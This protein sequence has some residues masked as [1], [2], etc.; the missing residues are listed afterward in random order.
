[1]QEVMVSVCCTTYNHEKYVRDALE[2][3]VDQET[4]FLY[5]VIVHDDASTD[6]TVEII[7]EYAEKYPDIIKPIYQEENQYSKQVNIYAQYIYPNTKGKYIA[8]CEGDD[9]WID[10]HKLQIQVDFMEKHTGFS[11]C[12][13]NTCFLDTRSGEERI[14]YGTEEKE[15]GILDTIY[16]GGQSFHTSSLLFYREYALEQPEFYHFTTKMKDYPM[17]IYLSYSGKIKYFPQVMSVYRVLTEGSWSMAYLDLGRQIE[18]LQELI[19]MLEGF[20]LYSDKQYHKEVQKSMRDKR[21]LLA[22]LQGDFETIHS[23]EMKEY[24]QKIPFVGKLGIFAREH[25]G[26]LYKMYRKVIDKSGK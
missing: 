14:F 3:F 20:D 12:V 21:F 9:Y 11:A 26:L 10:K 22:V 18:S 1:M 23:E 6:G 19:R 4:D 2:G 17:A 16:E 25:L 8:L 13:H 24:Y 15:L 7:R 5:E